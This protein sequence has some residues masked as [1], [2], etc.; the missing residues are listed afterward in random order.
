MSS[1]VKLEHLK[2]VFIDRHSKKEVIAVKDF[3]LTLR[4]GELLTLLG[5]SGCGKTTVL[6]MLAG[7]EKPTSGEILLNGEKITNRPPN[8]RDSAMVFQGYA[9][10]PHMNVRQ[11][12]AY[13]LKF[14][15]LSS[16]EKTSRLQKII[17]IV[18]LNGLEDRRT[19]ELSGGQQQR[20][21]LARALVVEPKILLFDEP[22]SNL[23][24][25][26]RETMRAE[27]RRVQQRLS[28]TA[29]YVTH[30]QI[31]ALSMSDRI[32]IINRGEIEQIGTPTEIYHSPRTKFVADFMGVTNFL[33]GKV[34]SKV[35]GFVGI[36]MADFSLNL[37]EEIPVNSGQAVLVYLRPEEV[38][39]D[40][41][42]AVKGEILELTYL[43]E[44][45][46]LQ[47]KLK[48]GAHL[49]IRTKFQNLTEVPRVGME[50][51]LK[52]NEA[53]VGYLEMGQ[54]T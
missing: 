4:P 41:A 14:R 26:L 13:G 31:E 52:F 38:K 16:S 18:G 15:K 45:F 20:V 5:P 19:S 12:V 11:N 29:V 50:L 44:K 2:K 3:N 43:G 47:I 37:K 40:P 21:A 42:S 27:I 28:I 53:R 9:L 23:D 10:F 46:D 30:D 36:K 32:V 54:G 33:E 1:E 34:E 17:E 48:S 24:A 6:R 8:K 51:G 35:S 7:F 49:N 39:I 22:L 25:K